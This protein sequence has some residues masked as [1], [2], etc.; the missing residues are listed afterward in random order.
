[1]PERVM[2]SFGL[3]VVMKDRPNVSGEPVD[4]PM[5][6]GTTVGSEILGLDPRTVAK[7][8][9]EG[10]LPAVK[11]GGSWRINRRKLMAM[12]EGVGE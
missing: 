10:K 6:C 11:I 2:H 4:E 12:I 8:C 1:M 5:A 7:L 3:E 9:R